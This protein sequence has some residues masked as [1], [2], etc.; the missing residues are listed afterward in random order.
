MSKEDVQKQILI[1]ISEDYH[2]N[3]KDIAEQKGISMNKWIVDI[4]VENLDSKDDIDKDED[5]SEIIEVFK[6]QLQ[7]KDDQIKQLHGLLNQQQ[8]LSLI[9]QKEKE[10]LMLE[11]ND[12]EEN[13][14][15]EENRPFWRRWFK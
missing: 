6:T 9:T 5:D 7:E 14:E 11:I 1:R 2:S 15:N 10:S 13:E 8:Q 3:I 4:L 12:I